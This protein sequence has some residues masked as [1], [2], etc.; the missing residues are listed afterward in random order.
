[1]DLGD[2]ADENI[3][4]LGLGSPVEKN[5]KSAGIETIKDLVDIINS[6]KLTSIKGIGQKRA[7]KIIEDLKVYLE[8]KGA[9]VPESETT[10]EKTENS[11]AN[12]SI[13]VLELPATVIKILEK[14]GISTLAQL[15]EALDADG[16]TNIRG[17]GA[18]RKKKIEEALTAYLQKGGQ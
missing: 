4:V 12:V 5:L 7:E 8:S 16:L 6:G 15:K 9:D 1:M 11:L 14:A 17:I 3:S 2:K 18:T 13:D 10:P